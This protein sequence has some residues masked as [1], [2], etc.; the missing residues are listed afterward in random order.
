MIH[1][2]KALYD[3]GNGLSQ[4]EIAIQLGISRNSV[5]KYLSMSADEISTY[6]AE[7]DRTKL[8]DV[9]RE[10]IVHLLVSYP[11]LSAVKVMRKL[12]AKH[13]DIAVSDRTVRRYV[14]Q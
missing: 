13:S 10:Y 14:E 5:R 2:I 4:R 1:K 3:S 11:N 12:R 6:Q 7:S 9:Y 8:L